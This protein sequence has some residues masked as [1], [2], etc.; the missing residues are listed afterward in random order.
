MDRECTA[1]VIWRYLARNA[2]TFRRILTEPI[3]IFF[4]KYQFQAGHIGSTAYSKPT[5]AAN[6][7]YYYYYYFLHHH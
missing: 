3:H 2:A 6:Y 7:Y 1:L 4:S 5:T